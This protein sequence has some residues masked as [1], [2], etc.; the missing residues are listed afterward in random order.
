MNNL[1]ELMSL[2][3]CSVSIEINPHRDYYETS[4]QEISKLENEDIAN[5]PNEVLGEMI[6][7]NTFIRVQ[8]YPNTPIGFYFC[9]HHDLDEAIN[10]VLEAVKNSNK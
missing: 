3:K 7:T 4:E 6:R 1:K 2:C 10:I 8:A 5:I 9:V